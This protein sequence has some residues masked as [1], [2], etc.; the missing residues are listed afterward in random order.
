MSKR[1][2]VFTTKGTV[3]TWTYAGVYCTFDEALEAVNQLAQDNPGHD[4]RIVEIVTTEVYH[5]TEDTNE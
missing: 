4:R 2:K 3:R 1:Y 5:S